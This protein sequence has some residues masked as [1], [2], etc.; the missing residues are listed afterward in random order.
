LVLN[1]FYLSQ[2]THL[3]RTTISDSF[4]SHLYVGCSTVTDSIMYKEDDKVKFG[5]PRFFFKFVVT[6]RSGLTQPCHF[7]PSAF[8]SYFR[9][10]G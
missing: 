9:T 10:C 7:G 2:I 6:L 4:T 3:R 8:T 1:G 5:F